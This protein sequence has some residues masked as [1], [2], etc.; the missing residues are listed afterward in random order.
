[1]G[2]DVEDLNTANG[3]FLLV[4]KSFEVQIFEDICDV[5]D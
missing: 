5:G 4:D 2:I 1:L 3:P